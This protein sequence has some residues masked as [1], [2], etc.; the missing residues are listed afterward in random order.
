MLIGRD[1]LIKKVLY[2]ASNN[3]SLFIKAG[4]GSGKTV[5]LKELSKL[6]KTSVYSVVSTKKEMLVSIATKLGLPIKGKRVFE[7]LDEIIFELEITNLVLLL[8]DVHEL[9]N[10]IKKTIIKMMN[11]GLIVICAGEKNILEIAETRMPA[12]SNREIEELIK[13]RLKEPDQSI[14]KLLQ[15]NCSTPQEV[16]Q[17]IRRKGSKELKSTQARK[18][19]INSLSIKKKEL[20]PLWLMGVAVTLMLSLRY[21]FYMIKQFNTGYTIAFTA[22]ILRALVSVRKR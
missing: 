17:A 11:K 16:V 1:E 14:I 3:Q 22:Y 4:T 19:F 8:D 5:L 10:S 9:T 18:S 15:N 6:I 20:M 21:Y 2:Y 7:L 12:L 13:S